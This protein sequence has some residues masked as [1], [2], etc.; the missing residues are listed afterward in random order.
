MAG[1]G[2][3]FGGPFGAPYPRRGPPQGGPPQS[4]QAGGPPQGG[5][6]GWGPQGGAGQGAAGPANPVGAGGGYN[7]MSPP[8]LPSPFGIG[9]RWGPQ[10]APRRAQPNP[11]SRWGHP[12]VPR[13]PQQQQTRFAG[14][15][16]PGFVGQ[17]QPV[18]AGQQ[19]SGFTG[20]QQPGFIGPAGAQWIA[21]TVGWSTHDAGVGTPGRTTTLPTRKWWIADRTA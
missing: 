5:Q 4:G 20:Q 14:Q 6:V 3:P 19:Q 2:G 18:F 10:A 11:R 1:R 15:Q 13:P 7:Q 12:M 16:Q 9:G 8:S 17:Q 21:G